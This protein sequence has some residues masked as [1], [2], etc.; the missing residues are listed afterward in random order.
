MDNEQMMRKAKE[1]GLERA[2]ELIPE[3]LKQALQNSQTL[4]DRLPRKIHW[5]SEPAHIFSQA[6]RREKDA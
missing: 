2:A 3:E 6:P 4:A 1:L 5:S